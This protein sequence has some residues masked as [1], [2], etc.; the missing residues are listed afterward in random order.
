MFVCRGVPGASTFIGFLVVTAGIAVVIYYE[1][2][3]K[4][5]ETAAEAAAAAVGTASPAAT[6]TDSAAAAAATS[7]AGGE[8]AESAIT[9]TL[10]PSDISG[11]TDPSDQTRDSLIARDQ[12]PSDSVAPAP[13]LIS[14]TSTKTKAGGYSQVGTNGTEVASASDA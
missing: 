2:K 13:S 6:N 11:A 1:D 14:S 7:N 5:A 3:R 4:K 9:L 8:S 12:I 10:T